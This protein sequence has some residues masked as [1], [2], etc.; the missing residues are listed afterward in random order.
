MKYAPQQDKRTR[1]VL[2]RAGGDP[3][4]LMVSSPK[5]A[6]DDGRHIND[7]PV[8]LPLQLPSTPSLTV[9]AADGARSRLAGRTSWN[10]RARL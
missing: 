9:D 2:V 5:L 3:M 10:G 6:D 4:S 8:T 1:G 7:D